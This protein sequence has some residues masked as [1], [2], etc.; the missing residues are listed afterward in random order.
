MPVPLILRW[1]ERVAAHDELLRQMRADEVIGAGPVAGSVN[2]GLWPGV[3]QG[4]QTKGDPDVA[5]ASREPWV[6]ANGYLAAYERALHPERPALL[7]H[8]HKDAERGVPYD[9]LELALIEARVHGGNFIL[10]VEP[11]YRRALLAAEPKAL[12]AWRQLARTAAWLRENEALL[13][14]PAAP[15]LTV[16]VEPGMATSEIA[17]LLHR[18][19]GTPALVAAGAL[20]APD[21]ARRFVLVAAGLKAVPASVHEHAAAGTT[22]VMDS[23][24]DAAW[25]PLKEEPDRVT[26]AHGKGVIVAYRKRIADPSEFALDVI[27]LVGHRR[28]A[29]RLWNAPSAIPLFT[30]GGLLHIIQYGSPLTGEIQVRVQGHFSRARLLRPDAEPVPL[31]LFRRGA[32]TEVFPSGI[33]RLGVI[34]FE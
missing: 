32:M 28:L 8:Q 34:Q 15:T 19:G 31:K 10:S 18:R 11:A 25:K 1:P 9:S 5:S 27:D 26:F 3:R 30:E 2:R 7:G 21:P 20:P 22:V 16:V 12:D 13:G 6:D 4:P 33:R 24:P 14:R 17:N 23:P 29:A